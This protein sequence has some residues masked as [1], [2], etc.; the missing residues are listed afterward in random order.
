MKFFRRY[1]PYYKENL[2]LAMPVILSQIGQI[3]VQLADTAMVGRY[4]GDDPTPLAAVSFATSFFYII[5]ISA[6]G[7]TF[8]LTPLVG[9]HF[10][11]DEK[12]RAREF[13]HNGLLLFT[14]I[15][16]ITI[17]LLEAA[18]PALT[19]IGQLMLGSG[20]DTSIA[21][22]VNIALPYYETLTWSMFPIMLFCVIK[23]FLEGV[24]NTRIAMATIIISNVVNIFL[25]WV[26]IFGELG[27][28]AMGAKGAGLATLIARTLQC[29]L[30]VSYFFSAPRFREY[31]SQL[32]RRST[33]CWQRIKD[34]MRV[35]FPI[36]FQMLM[37]A[38][39]FVVAGILVLAFGAEST[40]AYQIGV[41]MMNVTFMIVIAIGSATTIL[42]SFIYGRRTYDRLR[43]TV[44]ASYQMG[45]TWNVVVATIFVLL[46]NH[47]P[48]LFTT[49]EEVISIAGTMLVF[50]ALFQVSD[51]L[52]ALSI[53]ILRGLQDVKV[54]IPIVFISYVV[55]NI[56][57]GYLLAFEFGLG[58]NGLIV[59][60]IIGLSCSAVM[61]IARVL[62]N[63]KRLERKVE[64]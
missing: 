13:L 35:G 25:N 44:W 10:A 29:V 60:F 5:F 41:N 7:L 17:G 53:S 20:G 12:E 34:I 22:V 32:F 27:F 19:F 9:E 47:I 48:A 15:G 26:F 8:G 11:R 57:A 21:E 40:S 24:G 45:L 33:L 30:I 43:R 59:G 39:A 42:C 54:I 50:I 52:Q 64:N 18:K 56:P 31:T 55:V 28:K 2:R 61:T 14:L 46:R 4:G 6:M 1:K 38:S 23:Q 36:S 49:N 58:A 3:T 16:F 63:I 62:Y 51:C 37:E